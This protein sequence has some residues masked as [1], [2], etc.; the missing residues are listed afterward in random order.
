[1]LDKVAGMADGGR[2]EDFLAAGLYIALN[3][4]SIFVLT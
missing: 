4:V 2:N 3:S 1:M